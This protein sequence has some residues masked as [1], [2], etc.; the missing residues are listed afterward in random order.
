MNFG[1]LSAGYLKNIK[2]LSFLLS[3]D[4]SFYSGGGYELNNSLSVATYLGLKVVDFGIDYSFLF[5]E[6]TAHRVT[7][8]LSGY[9][10]IKKIPIFD[11]IILTPGISML[12]GSSNVVTEQYP[13]DMI[14]HYTQGPGS[15]RWGNINQ[16]ISDYYN[17]REG[18]VFGIMNYNLSFP[19]KFKLRNYSLSMSYNYNIP[20][21]LPGELIDLSPYSYYSVFLFYALPF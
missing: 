6:A 16:P 3:Y 1:V 12:S 13:L 19:V 7:A 15:R 4:R 20:K 2:V 8:S 14:E 5:G 11:R 9:F 17:P 18:K 10:A 21:K